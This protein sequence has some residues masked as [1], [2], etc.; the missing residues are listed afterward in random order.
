MLMEACPRLRIVSVKFSPVGTL[1]RIGC[2]NHRTDQ[3]IGDFAK[4]LVQF[5]ELEEVEVMMRPPEAG[6]GHEDKLPEEK[7][8]RFA[9]KAVQIALNAAGP[10][11]I[12]DLRLYV[13]HRFLPNAVHPLSCY[14]WRVNDNS[15]WLHKNG[16]GGRSDN[17]ED[18]VRNTE[19]GGLDQ[20]LH[21]AM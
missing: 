5:K 13:G 20:S 8:F 14:H 17:C 16:S 4:I 15:E 18:E 6:L 2:T 12:S 1:M 11:K 21:D 10:H 9:A 7:R 3:T 19:L